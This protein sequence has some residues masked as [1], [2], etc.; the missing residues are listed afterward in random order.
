MVINTRKK[1][2]TLMS[3]FEFFFVTCLF[4][5]TNFFNSKSKCCSS[6]V[7]RFRRT[8]FVASG[9]P[10]QWSS[11]REEMADDDDSSLWSLDFRR[12]LGES[13]LVA[14][15]C[16]LGDVIFVKL[17]DLTRDFEDKSLLATLKGCFNEPVFVSKFKSSNSFDW[18]LPLLCAYIWPKS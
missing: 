8:D 18:R 1:Y 5:L 17:L 10:I 6:L 4:V 12:P 11:S 15:R 7:F 3:H 14:L 2:E 9:S 13:R 16:N